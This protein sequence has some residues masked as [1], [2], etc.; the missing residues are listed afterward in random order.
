MAVWQKILI[1]WEPCN[2]GFFSYAAALC[3]ISMISPQFLCIRDRNTCSVDLVHLGTACDPSFRTTWISGFTKQ[4]RVEPCADPAVTESSVQGVPYLIV[5]VTYRS[6]LFNLTLGW[7][8]RTGLWGF[9]TALLRLCAPGPHKVLGVWRGFVLLF[10]KEDVCKMVAGV[11]PAT[12]DIPYLVVS[13]L[14]TSRSS[15]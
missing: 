1:L 12:G 5:L 10:A 4:H 7:V 2:S 9:D 6:V 14:R 3:A 13:V 15:A 8:D 11:F